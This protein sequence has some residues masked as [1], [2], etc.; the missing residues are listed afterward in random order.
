M[1]LSSALL[2]NDLVEG[3]IRNDR[4]AQEKLYKQYCGAM[5]NLCITYTK[6]DED[7]IEVVQDGFLKVFQQIHR[8]DSSKSSLYTW[9]RTVELRTAI[10]FLRKKNQKPEP[11]E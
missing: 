4:R 10:D 9:I 2:S 5:M 3:C 8:F 7:A 6:N 11:V 1:T